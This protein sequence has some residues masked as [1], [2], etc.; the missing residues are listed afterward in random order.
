MSTIDCP[1]YLLD[2][3][4]T[5]GTCSTSEPPV[6]Q[7]SCAECCNCGY[8]QFESLLPYL[9]EINDK[10]KDDADRFVE[11]EF[12]LREQIIEISRLFDIDA[13]VAPGYFSKSHF[14]TTRIYPTNGT[15]YIKVPEFVPNTLEVRT[16][17]NVLLDD[18][19]YG[20]KDGF[21][22]YLPCSRH[23]SCGCT[24]GCGEAKSARPVEWPNTCYKVTAR[25]GSQCADAAVQRA[26]RDYL[27]ENYRVQDPVIAINNGIPVSRTFREP[28]SWNTYISNFKKKRALYSQFAIA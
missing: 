28:H 10:L 18:S 14:R 6:E 17:N 16:A 7:S 23:E 5:A 27:I 3:N 19:S 15:R 12:K 1:I 26:V 9:G 24:G 13:G 22:V 21:L 8:L 25:W 20:Y 2:P 4:A 11:F